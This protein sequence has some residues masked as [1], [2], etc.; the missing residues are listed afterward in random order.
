MST[1]AKAELLP[2][3]PMP[4]G[5]PATWVYL[6]ELPAPAAAAEQVERVCRQL[7][8]GRFWRWW[9][10]SHLESIVREAKRVHY[11]WG[12][13][14]VH[15]QTP[16]GEVVTYAGEPG[17]DELIAYLLSRSPQERER[18]SRITVDSWSHFGLGPP[19]SEAH[20]A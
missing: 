8:W 18:D 19:E 5:D 12:K 20:E 16:R 6:D 13:T 11:F 1:T 15:H 9:Y 2:G 3:R 10:K 14:V 4:N 17:S 7:G